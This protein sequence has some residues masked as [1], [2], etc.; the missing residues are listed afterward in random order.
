MAGAPIYYLEPGRGIHSVYIYMPD[1]EFLQALKEFGRYWQDVHNLS[2]ERVQSKLGGMQRWRRYCRKLPMIREQLQSFRDQ[3]MQ[4]YDAPVDSETTQTDT[5]EQNGLASQTP[6]SSFDNLL[7][8][9]NG[10]NHKRW[11]EDKMDQWVHEVADAMDDEFQEEEELRSTMAEDLE[12]QSATIERAT[13][14]IRI[15]WFLSLFDKTVQVHGEWR[16]V[17]WPSMK[18]RHKSGAL[19]AYDQILGEETEFGDD[20]W[21]DSA[22]W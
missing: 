10:N 5:T 21:L 3:G 12:L 1:A 13:A 8:L 14:A 18:Y 15:K 20:P 9:I 17:E 19:R 7:D 4:F 6:P 16:E 11:Y 22:D 2:A